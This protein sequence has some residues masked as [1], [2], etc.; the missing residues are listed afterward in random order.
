LKLLKKI[1]RTVQ[2]AAT[3]SYFMTAVLLS[4]NNYN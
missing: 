2:Y 3:F 1:W 4:W